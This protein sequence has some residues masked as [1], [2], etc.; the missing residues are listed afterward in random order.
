MTRIGMRQAQLIF[1]ICEELK[2]YTW[3]DVKKRISI[4]FLTIKNSAGQMPVM[5]SDKRIQQYI[6]H[7]GFSKVILK[8]STKQPT[9]YRFVP[10]GDEQ[11]H[12]LSY[13]SRTRRYRYRD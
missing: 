13:K 7:G 2:A 3:L 1:S 5:P 6:L 10:P 11:R 8:G 4:I 9:L 12:P